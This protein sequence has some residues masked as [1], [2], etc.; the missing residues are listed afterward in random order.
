[1]GLRKL[2]VLPIIPGGKHSPSTNHKTRLSE[3]KYYSRFLSNY[4]FI[5]GCAASWLF[6]AGFL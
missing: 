3:I 1:M 4:L 6:C 2:L 5:F